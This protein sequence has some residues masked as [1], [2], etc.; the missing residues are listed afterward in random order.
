MLKTFSLADLFDIAAQAVPDKLAIVY[1]QDR[2]TY[3]VMANRIN[4]I[5]A[6][7]QSQGVTRGDT[8]G[9]QLYNS[10]AYMECYL[11]AC[12]LGAIPFNINYRYLEDELDYLYKDSKAKVIVFSDVLSERVEKVLLKNP[13]ISLAVIDGQKGLSNR[14]TMEEIRANDLT[15]V[16]VQLQDEDISLLYTGGTTGMPKG[17]MWEHKALFYGAFAGGAMFFKDGPISKPEEL[18]ERILKVQSG[19]YMA[20]APLMHG[21]AFWASLISLLSGIT[22]VLNDQKEF[23]P[24]HILD[25]IDQEKV[26]ML[27][28]VGDAMAAPLLDELNANPGHW[29]LPNL[30]YFGNGGAVLSQ[31]LK[32][33]IL[34]HLPA[35]AVTGDG[36]GSSEAGVIGAGAKPKD[37]EGFMTM[38]PNPLL[39][40]IVDGVREAEVGELGILAKTGSIPLGYWGD[41]KKTA[42]TFVQFNGQRYVLLGDTA[43]R[44]ADGSITILGRDSLCINTGGEKV[45]VEEVEQVVRACDGVK[46]VNVVGIPDE[47]WGNK[48]VAL[49]SKKPGFDVTPEQI[50]ETARKQLSG[51]KVPKNILFT[52]EIVRG[53]NG[54]ADY[55]WAK[56][57]VIE[58]LA[59]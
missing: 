13:Q 27:N 6:W 42:T 19:P 11:A 45:F 18:G 54:K 56:N 25:L 57:L 7:F 12:K 50:I 22:L 36:M 1:G 52:D 55:R 10:T 46:D 51:Y 39:K 58:M 23:N 4:K 53:A 48:V 34:K 16:P 20:I 37:G 31:R 24:K 14:P 9:L 26:A 2:V 33:G 40:V 44:S 21:A 59:K 32:D 38:P 29:K 35:G 49:V 3:H 43:K 17:V 41:E 8:V 28:V 15:F 47:R 5:A 30:Y